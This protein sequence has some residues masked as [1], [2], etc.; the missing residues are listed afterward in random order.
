MAM[1]K[2]PAPVSAMRP[3]NLNNNNKG[4]MIK[5]KAGMMKMGGKKK[6]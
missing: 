5:P 1:V 2:K 6:R 3:T 4:G